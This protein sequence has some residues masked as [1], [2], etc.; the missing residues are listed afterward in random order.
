MGE[1]AGLSANC[2]IL[3]LRRYVRS[4]MGMRCVSLDI[5]VFCDRGLGLIC[6]FAV[7]KKRQ[8]FLHIV[9]N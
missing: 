3:H 6:E 7:C 4:G 1:S 8:S 2:R 5:H 9:Y